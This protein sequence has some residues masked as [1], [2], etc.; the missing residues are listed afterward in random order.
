MSAV[1]DNISNK[2]VIGKYAHA[3]LSIRKTANNTYILVVGVAGNQGGAGVFSQNAPASGKNV[4]SVASID[5]SFYPAN[6]LNLA[7]IPDKNF[8]KL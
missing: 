4:M 7:I 8:R 6:V 5:N 3:T 1:A 2:G